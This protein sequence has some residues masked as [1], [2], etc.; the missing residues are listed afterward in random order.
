MTAEAN[1]GQLA[2]ARAAGSRI[3]MLVALVVMVVI[4]NIDRNVVSILLEPIRKEFGLHDWQLGLLTGPSFTILYSIGTLAASR[5]AS[6]FDRVSILAAAGGLWSALTLIC[7]F[8]PSFGVLVVARAGVGLAES[9][10]QVPSHALIADRFQGKD[11]T[12]AM[13]VYASGAQLGMLLALPLGGLIASAYGWRAAFWVLSAPGLVLAVALR[14]T[15]QDAR[16]PAARPETSAAPDNLFTSMAAMFANPALRHAIIGA[17]LTTTASSAYAAFGP[18]YLMRSH[19]VSPREVGLLVSTTWGPIAIASALASGWITS[20]LV[21][22]DR[23]WN[24]WSPAISQA[25]CFVPAAAYLLAPNLPL[26]LVA[27]GVTAVLTVWWLGPTFALAQDVA[28]EAHR[29]SAAAALLFCYNFIGFGA[30]A[31][32]AGIFSDLLR[33]ALGEDS[34]RA[35]LLLLLPLLLWSSAHFVRS[36]REIGKL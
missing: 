34:L 25:L 6:R 36:A 7:G 23:R 13:G 9:G 20:R 19:H 33:P 18:A 21:R 24:A 5:F 10:C 4:C 16:P 26:A 3:Y 1:L 15:V 27:L 30:G 8:A 11:R 22:R 17:T 14:L 12:L 2:G 32:L 29:A 35:G 31:L 28:G